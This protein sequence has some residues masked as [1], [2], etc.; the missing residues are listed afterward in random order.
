MLETCMNFDGGSTST[1]RG[2][3]HSRGPK[4]WSTEVDFR[5][6]ALTTATDCAYVQVRR[7]D[8]SEPSG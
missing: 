1:L 8:T 2:R 3:S 6:L 7:T 4:I 5:H